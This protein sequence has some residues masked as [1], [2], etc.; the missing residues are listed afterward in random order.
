MQFFGL[1]PAAS[2]PSR[3]SAAPRK[4]PDLSGAQ[5]NWQYY[6][7]QAASRRAAYLTALNGAEGSPGVTVQLPEGPVLGHSSQGCTAAAQRALYGNYRA[8]FGAASTVAQLRPLWLG[9]VA[10]D[11]AFERAVARWS[12]CMRAAGYGYRSPAGLADRIR[13]QG[14]AAAEL[15]NNVTAIRA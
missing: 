6:N 1:E 9:P 11:S 2:P 15:A 12:R 8:W 14:R 7:R 3:A 5:R 13:D 4:I 10:R